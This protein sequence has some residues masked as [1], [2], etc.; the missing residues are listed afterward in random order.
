MTE[1]E[2]EQKRREDVAAVD[3]HARERLAAQARVDGAQDKV[4]KFEDHVKNLKDDLKAAKAHLAAMQEVHDKARKR[5]DEVL[6][7]G[8]VSIGGE[9][10]YATAQT[11]HAQGS[12]N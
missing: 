5:A 1:Q 7:D 2:I 3:Y 4:S 11:A 6:A 8:P 9:M 12:V 10:V